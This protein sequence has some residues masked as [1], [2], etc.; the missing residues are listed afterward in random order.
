M[1][2]RIKADKDSIYTL[3]LTACCIYYFTYKFWDVRSRGFKYLAL[4]F[5]ALGM[6][7]YL[8]DLLRTKRSYFANR[9][10][11]ILFI[12]LESVFLIHTIIAKNDNQRMLALYQYGFYTLIL[13]SCIFYSR[14]SDISRIFNILRFLGAGLAVLSIYEVVTKVYLIPVDAWYGRV[15]H[16]GI[17]FLRAKVFSGSPMVYGLMMAILSLIA[18]DFY[19]KKRKTIDLLI[20]IFNLIG[21]LASFSRGPWISFVGG[22][23]FYFFLDARSS[24]KKMER[25]MIG[26]T[27][28]V[29]FLAL[30]IEIGSR[31]DPTLALLKARTLSIFEWGEK[32]EWSSN[33]TRLSIWIYSIKTIFEGHNWFTGIGAAATGARTILTGGYVTESGLIRRYVEFG[34]P[35]ATIY[36]LF[37]IG[38]IKKG[39]LL[40]K[41]SKN[42]YL[43]LETAI[44]I[45]ILIEDMILQ[46]TEE[47]SIT[48]FMWLFVTLLLLDSYK[49]DPNRMDQ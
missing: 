23:V 41:K 47:I 7:G 14:R 27:I 33:S 37:L 26:G 15:D 39:F 45:C 49:C 3:I 19:Y 11:F 2:I 18:F 32:S 8:L 10:Y 44:L 24:R 16:G 25:Y 1:G 40:G 34:I 35:I 46:I 42:N 6:V 29:L 48:F 43:F 12:F 38:S 9:I 13:L 4:T 17:W 30:M 22:I 20:L 28:L 31:L 36:Y 21:L 5:L